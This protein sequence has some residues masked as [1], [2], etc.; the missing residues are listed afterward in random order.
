MGATFK[1]LYATD[2]Y[3]ED[4]AD[5]PLGL[6]G[7]DVRKSTVEITLP[8][9]SGYQHTLTFLRGEWDRVLEMFNEST[10]AAVERD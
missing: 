3:T 8:D 7:I 4:D 6:A 5:I 1:Y 9:S 2:I 10:R